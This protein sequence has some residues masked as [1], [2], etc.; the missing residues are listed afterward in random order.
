[1]I[2][3]NIIRIILSHKRMFKTMICFD[4]L[5]RHYAEATGDEISDDQLFAAIENLKKVGLLEEPE[6]HCYTT[7]IE[8]IE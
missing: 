5:F 4:E 2:E 3:R 7:T 1:M 6:F 8:S